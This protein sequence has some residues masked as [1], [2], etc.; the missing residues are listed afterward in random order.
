MALRVRRG[1]DTEELKGM[2]V[3]SRLWAC[4]SGLVDDPIVPRF[5]LISVMDATESAILS[6]DCQNSLLARLHANGTLQAHDVTDDAEVLRATVRNPYKVFVDPTGSFIIATA[7]DGDLYFFAATAEDLSCRVSLCLGFTVPSRGT[8]PILVGES[9][10]WSVDGENVRVIVGTQ[11]LG[12]LIPVVFTVGKGHVRGMCESAVALP[13][14]V[15]STLP[16]VGLASE[17][18]MDT[19]LLMVST[20]L[21]LYRISRASHGNSTMDFSRVLSAVSDGSAS[22]AIKVV[23]HSRDTPGAGGLSL[24]RSREASP[25]QSYAWASA[26]GVFH[27]LF[28]RRVDSDTNEDGVETAAPWAHETLLN[29]AKLRPNIK[30]NS[31]L[32]VDPSPSPFSLPCDR[33]PI[34]IALTAFHMILLYERRCIVL[35]H[36][37]GLP[38]SGGSTC[39]AMPTVAE[40]SSRVR[41]DPF[42]SVV[43][44]KPLKDVVRDVEGRRTY[45]YSESNLW[46][47]QIENEHRRQWMLFLDCA[48]NPAETVPFRCRLF[49]AAYNLC[50]YNNK[51]RSLV[52]SLL[53][54]FYLEVGAV[55]KAVWAM[56]D[57]DECDDVWAYLGTVRQLSLLPVVAEKRVELLS[58]FR[59]SP[60]TSRVPLCCLIVVVVVEKLRSMGP[61][62]AAPG[63]V[64]QEAA[65]KLNQFLDR[66][67]EACPDLRENTN[68]FDVLLRLMEEQGCGDCALHLAQRTGQNQFVIA[69][70]VSHSRWKEATLALTK[71]SIRQEEGSAELWYTFSPTLI[72]HCPVALVTGILKSTSRELQGGRPP[73]L[74]MDRLMPAFLRYTPSM[75]EDASGLGEDEHEHQVIVLLEQFVHHFGCTSQAVHHYY[76]GLLAQQQDIERLDD[77]LAVSP[78]YDR[79]VALRLCLEHRCFSACA[80]LYEN[81][82]LYEDALMT[83]LECCFLEESPATADSWSSTSGVTAMLYR[84]QANVDAALWKRL[85]L[86]FAENVCRRISP[87]AALQVVE[88]SR[89]ALQLED[90]L[91]NVGE[92]RVVHDFKEAIIKSLDAYSADITALQKRHKESCQTAESV[93][94]E[95]Q[96]L[97]HQFGYVTP[98]QRCLLCHQLIMQG[99]MPYILYPSC[100]HVVHEACAIQRLVDIGGLEAFLT[101]EVEP[102][103]LLEG[104]H[105]VEELAQMDCVIC[106][107]AA[108]VEIDIPLCDEEP[109]WAL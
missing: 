73:S 95:M 26:A 59:S 83:M 56:A 52:Q 70:D 92:S 18:V 48:L 76:I 72:Q 44:M 40:V 89:G 4:T 36:P 7:L 84:I 15:S 79:H 91:G 67:L 12:F 81:L 90:I 74:S 104:I 69:Y 43:H 71:A 87:R 68:L 6:M 105:S 21:Q 8:T 24:Y 55:D 100:R 88:A 16:I 5:N 20:P 35:N 51:A 50:R 107:E 78:H 17:S 80:P 45:L 54:K 11:Q 23:P 49:N 93:K 62:I 60:D 86:L 41:F 25:A 46:E 97:T 102:P 33:P 85:W 65:R 64:P 98:N 53:G 29:F 19:F 109:S 9:L 99:G 39:A 13:G 31:E 106:G 66:V 27:G 61:L 28:S 94:R 101:D 63:E 103:R 3:G 32:G 1:G 47:L 82:R 75:N 30:N 10:C 34:A 57:C 96:E 38:W 108:I 14:Y 2:S 77:I 37:A 42:R 22:V 58:C